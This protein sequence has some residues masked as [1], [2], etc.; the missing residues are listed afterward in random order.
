[1]QKASHLRDD[2]TLVN[3]EGGQLHKGDTRIQPN[4]RA[5]AIQDELLGSKKEE[6]TSM[7]GITGSKRRSGIAK[8]DKW[9]V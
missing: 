2:A 4:I 3:A 6:I 5:R 1:M 8:N 7:E 9:M